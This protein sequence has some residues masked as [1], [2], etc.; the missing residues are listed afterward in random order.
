MECEMCKIMLEKF[1]RPC[2]NHLFPSTEYIQQKG[3]D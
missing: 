1:G 3:G 2:L